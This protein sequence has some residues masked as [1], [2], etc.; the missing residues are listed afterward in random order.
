MRALRTFGVAL[1]TVT[2]LFVTNAQAAIDIQD[3]N[4]VSLGTMAQAGPALE[5]NSWSVNWLANAFIVPFTRI[6]ATIN[7]SGSDVF[8]LV[9][10]PGLSTSL[11]GWSTT[12][13]TALVGE[14]SG[15]AAFATS[16][17]THFTGDAT[18]QPGETPVSLYFEYYFQGTMVARTPT[19]YWNAGTSE[20]D[21]APVPEPTTVIAGALL[22]L[23]FAVSTVRFVRKRR[24]A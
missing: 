8:E 2:M 12:V 22:L 10:T 4:G 14:I 5:G 15:P 9:P 23:P 17:T 19:L 3:A 18:V 7:S 21:Y 11:A 13:N 24:A 6:T 20:F 16:F 1:A